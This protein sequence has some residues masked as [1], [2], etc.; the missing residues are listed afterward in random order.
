M[1][2]LIFDTETTGMYNFRALPSD[3]SQPEVLQLCAK[4]SVDGKVVSSINVFVTGEKEIEEKAYEV[5]RI[6]REFA[7]SIG[8]S[9]RRMCLLFQGMAEQADVIVGH[10][11]DFDVKMLTAAMIREGG[12]AEIFKKK[13]IYCTMRE[14]TNICKIPS[15]KKPGQFK[16]PSLAE[17]YGILVDPRGFENAHDAEADVL[18]THEVYRVL[19]AQKN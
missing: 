9:R 18:A 3:H 16:W 8:I 12:N 5:H 1:R 10:N 7:N 17:A 11:V 4:M 6:S 14:S 19:M 2:S 13:A 15:P